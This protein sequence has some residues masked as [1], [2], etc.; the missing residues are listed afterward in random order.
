MNKSKLPE[1]VIAKSLLKDFSFVQ[2]SRIE[3]FPGSITPHKGEA[4]IHQEI[5]RCYQRNGESAF[6]I[7]PC[8]CG[9]KW[10]WG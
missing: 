3:F 10:D 8:Q 6:I 1:I 5:I 9:R 4:E 2:L 7:S